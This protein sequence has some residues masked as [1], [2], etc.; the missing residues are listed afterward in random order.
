MARIESLIPFPTSL[1]GCSLADWAEAQ[2][3][4]E[5]RRSL[6]RSSLRERLRGNLF[7]DGEDLDVQLDLLMAEVDR[8]KDAAQA[9]YPFVCTDRG[10]V[11]RIEMVDETPYEFLLWLSI[12][13]AYRAQERFGE[14]DQFFDDLVKQGLIAYLGPNAKG[15]CFGFPSRDGRPRGFKE[16]VS[17][18]A[19]LL[20]LRTGLMPRRSKVKDG[21]VDVV[22]WKPFRDQ[23][24][25]FIVILCQCTVQKDWTGKAKDI[26]VGKW[27]GWI[28]FGHDPVTAIAVPFAIP[29]TFER[30]DELRR[31]VH[32]VLDRM[33]PGRTHSHQRG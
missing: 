6:S 11:S 3:F 4:V 23:R 25:G 27:R 28:D 19:S 9:L 2:I 24:S 12:S 1:E 32:I 5:K 29:P 14:I 13:P 17:W 26:V 33:R 21:G 10:S 16:A 30:W 31:T 18:L 22:V 7:N 8:R 15:V 20:G